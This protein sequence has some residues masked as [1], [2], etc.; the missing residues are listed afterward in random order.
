MASDKRAS[1]FVVLGLLSWKAADDIRGQGHMG[2]LTL[3]E[4]TDL[5]ELLHCVLP[6]HLVKDIVRATL[7]WHMEELINSRV[8][9][10]V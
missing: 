9:H 3:E 7:D 8:L 1:L 6:V 4:V 10:D 2:H 5:I